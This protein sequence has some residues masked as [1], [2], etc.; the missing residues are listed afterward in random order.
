MGLPRARLWTGAHITPGD[1]ECPRKSIQ[2]FHRE[3]KRKIPPIRGLAGSGSRLQRLQKSTNGPR[4]PVP[5][6]LTEWALPPGAPTPRL[7]RCV[8]SR[9]AGG[10]LP[11]AKQ[12]SG[13]ADASS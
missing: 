6:S 12:H 7:R 8:W 3:E 2:S 13:V 11:R 9:R 10:S 5:W 4:S 1:L